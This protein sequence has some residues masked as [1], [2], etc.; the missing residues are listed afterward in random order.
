MDLMG[1]CG[2]CRQQDDPVHI[3]MLYKEQTMNY[4]KKAGLSIHPS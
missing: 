4:K 3:K 2:C 1:Q